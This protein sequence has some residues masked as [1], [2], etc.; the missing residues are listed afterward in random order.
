MRLR[1]YLTFTRENV[2]KPIIWELI[3]TFDVVV[4]I[5]TAEVKDGMG[6]MALEIDG[7]PETVEKAVA[8]LESKGVRVEPIEQSVVAG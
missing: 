4:N 6:L 1:A 5:R 7:K 2:T 8:W 3:K